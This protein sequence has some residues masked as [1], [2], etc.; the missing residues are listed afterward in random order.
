MVQKKIINNKSST[1]SDSEALKLASQILA[2]IAQA[3]EA[4]HRYDDPKLTDSEY[5]NLKIE[6][7]RIKS[8]HPKILSDLQE[9]KRVGAQVS[10]SFEKVKHELKMFSLSNGNTRDDIEKFGKSIKSFLGLSETDKLDFC[11][12]PKID[13]LSLSLRYEDGILRRALTR[14]DGRYGE[15]VTKNALEISNVPKIIDVKMRV[16]EVRGEVYLG[17]KDFLKL[18]EEQLRNGS[19][20]FANPRNAAAGSLRQLDSTKTK[21]RKLAFFAYSWGETSKSIGNTHYD[22]VEELKRLG[23][24][25]NPLSRRCPTVGALIEHYNELMFLRATLNY[26][27]DGVVYKVDNLD[28]QERLGFR[29]TTPRWAIAH[30]FPAEIAITQIKDID[31]QV[32]R[33]GSISPVARLEPVNIGGVIVSNATLHNEDYIVGRSSSGE[34]IRGGVD[35]RVGDVVEVFRAGDVIPKVNSV[36]L[37]K[38]GVNTR[39][40]VFPTCC[41]VCGSRL[42]KQVTDSV[43]RC[44]GGM[45]CFSQAIEKINHFVSKKAFNI[46][47]FGKKNVIFFYKKKWLVDPSDIFLLEKQ[48]GSN[49][50]NRLEDLQGWGQQSAFKLF[51]AINNARE[52]SLSNLIYSL[53]IRHVGE[54]VS[55]LLEKHY[56]NW[57]NFFDQASKARNNQSDEWMQLSLIDGIGETIASSIVEF[58]SSDESNWVTSKLI[59]HLNIRSYKPVSLS[60]TPLLDLVIV[61]TGALKKMTRSEAK[62]RVEQLGGKVV[63]S[64]SRNTDLLIAG[65]N[66]GSKLKKA[67]EL[68]IKVLSEIEWLE[69]LGA[70]DG[71]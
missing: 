5:D 26:D 27:I 68:G 13:G 7:E 10:K 12:E 34:P 41:P 43:L 60:E 69:T 35:I 49:S 25:V 28:F 8:S 55:T 47:G 58:F 4:Y 20:V 51:Q 56:C 16:F 19:K 2:N 59:N 23:F 64:I 3:D 63:T 62:A 71:K 1:I 39:P 30:K 61:F 29:A 40:Y 44:T 57:T 15:N 50:N 36:I 65:E 42:T 9:T 14:G 32:G 45:K 24:D 70:H 38:R 54:Q 46:D 67:S 66:S 6:L 37:S 18:N 11:S 33:T 21:D 52:I 48:Y 17:K 31:I 22:A 53:G